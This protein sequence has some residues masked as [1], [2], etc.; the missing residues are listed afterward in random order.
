M[1]FINFNTENRNRQQIKSDLFGLLLEESFMNRRKLYSFIIL[2]R[3]FEWQTLRQKTQPKGSRAVLLRLFV[4]L[5][6]SINAYY[7]NFYLHL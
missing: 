4:L 5:Y 2:L 3:I 1:H 7:F 6:S